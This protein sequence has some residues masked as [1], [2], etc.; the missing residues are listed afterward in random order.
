MLAENERY[1]CEYSLWTSN[2]LTAAVVPEDLHRLVH[3]RHLLRLQRDLADQ[4]G[5]ALHSLRNSPWLG[6]ETAKRFLGEERY[7]FLSPWEANKAFDIAFSYPCRVAPLGRLPETL[8]AYETVFWGTW[9]D[10][11]ALWVVCF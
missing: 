3:D 2:F 4:R 7:A 6:T 11:F 1:L 8:D 5:A 10:F 9:L